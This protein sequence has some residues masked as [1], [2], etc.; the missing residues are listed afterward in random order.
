M[1]LESAIIVEKLD[2][3]VEHA[4]NHLEK[5]KLVDEDSLVDEDVGVVAEEVADL[6]QLEDIEPI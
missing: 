5:E 3:R 1:R 6:A 2:T 4:R